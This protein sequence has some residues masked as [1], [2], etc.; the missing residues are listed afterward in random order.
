[1]QRT[2]ILLKPD[3]IQRGLVGEILAR[4]EKADL[5]IEKCRLLQPDVDHWRQHYADLK[6]RQPAAFDRTTRHLAGKPVVAVILVGANAI[7]K[8]RSLIGATDPLKAA[9][10]TIRGDLGNDSIASADAEN[11]STA[12]LVHA[13]DAEASVASEIA[14]WFA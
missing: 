7:Q 5:R 12:N 4:F 2:L 11:R 9:P 13:A 1:M 10:G 14:L 6:S 8:A 3:A